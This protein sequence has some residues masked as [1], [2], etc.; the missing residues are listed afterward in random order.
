MSKTKLQLDNP[1]Y[2]EQYATIT[3]TAWKV[4]QADGSGKLSD[5]WLNTKVTSQN[6]KEFLAGENLTAGES[7]YLS[8]AHIIQNSSDQTDYQ[9]TMWKA[10]T[11]LTSAT[12]TAIKKIRLNLPTTG[13]GAT[14]SIRAVSS[15]VPTGSDI[16]SKTATITTSFGNI[17]EFAFSTPVTV[18]PNTTYAIVFR[19]SGDSYAIREQDDGNVYANGNYASSSNGGSTWT[20]TA[21]RDLWFEVID[22]TPF[23]IYKTNATSNDRLANNFIG[24]V[25]TTT[26]I[27]NNCPVAVFGISSIFS[28]LTVGKTYFLSDTPGAISTTAGSQSRKIGL[29]VSDTEL[30]IIHDNP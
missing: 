1:D 24:I 12:A 6:I 30:L 15:S 26:S 8:D 20:A 16:E 4:P 11:F 18:S 25:N 14:V 27:N 17:R 19:T 10:Q 21:N 5:S 22:D 3:P 7:V 28:S 13:T 2:I 9:K 23:K 29:A